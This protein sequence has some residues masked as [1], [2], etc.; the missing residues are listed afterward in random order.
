[1]DKVSNKLI[2]TR[3]PLDVSRISYIEALE[4]KC[5]PSPKGERPFAYCKKVYSCRGAGHTTETLRQ[6]VHTVFPEIEI[7]TEK[8]EFPN[9]KR[10]HR[11]FLINFSSGGDVFV[12]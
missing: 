1:M 3:C 2:V 8:I 9:M 6:K 5:S 10:N 12:F 11:E 4:R 7:E